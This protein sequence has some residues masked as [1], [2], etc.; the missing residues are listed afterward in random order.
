MLLQ[1]GNQ[2][3]GTKK[4]REGT[5]EVR[6]RKQWSMGKTSVR[7]RLMRGTEERKRNSLIHKENSKFLHGI[8]FTL[9][10]NSPSQH[11]C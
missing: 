5:E 7:Y 3:K 1:E 10:K 8:I 9:V 4:R 2:R 6:T 11:F